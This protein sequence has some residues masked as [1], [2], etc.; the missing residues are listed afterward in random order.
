MTTAQLH[1]KFE[2]NGEI[3]DLAIGQYDVDAYAD[4]IGGAI[5]TVLDA[6]YLDVSDIV[7]AVLPQEDVKTAWRA[8]TK[9]GFST[10]QMTAGILVKRLGFAGA[11]ATPLGFAAALDESQPGDRLVAASYGHGHGSIALLFEAVPGVEDAHAGVQSQLE[12][13]DQLTYMEYLKHTGG[14]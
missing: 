1:G 7:H 13:G 6:N 3:T 11:G 2:K 4:A 8:G 14:I 12:G 5:R 9:F 10:D